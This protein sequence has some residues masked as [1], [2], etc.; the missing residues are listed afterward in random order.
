M[1]QKAKNRQPKNAKASQRVEWQREKETMI[2]SF[3]GQNGA[4]VSITASPDSGRKFLEIRRGYFS[5]AVTGMVPKSGVL[6]P[7]E[8][9]EDVQGTRET[10]Q[11]ALDTLDAHAG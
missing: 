11:A 10:L 8:N 4:R 2:T 7:L 3:S 1:A 5:T 9:E 6:L